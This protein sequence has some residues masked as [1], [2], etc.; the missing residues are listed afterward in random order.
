MGKK[1]VLQQNLAYK[2]IPYFK[3]DELNAWPSFFWTSYTVLAQKQ[4]YI[5]KL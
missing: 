1:Q 4:A 2:A 5:P 3:V